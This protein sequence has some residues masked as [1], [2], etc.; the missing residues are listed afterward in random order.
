MKRKGTELVIGEELKKGSIWVK[1]I[2]QCEAK[3][4]WIW[5]PEGGLEILVTPS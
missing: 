1:I 5:Y 4:V 2:C 3:G